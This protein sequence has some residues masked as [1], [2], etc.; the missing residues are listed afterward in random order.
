MPCCGQQKTDIGFSTQTVTARQSSNNVSNPGYRYSIYFEY[1]GNTGLTVYG[2]ATNKKYRFERPGSRVQIDPR[3]RP[4]LA[5]VAN[6][7]EV[8][9]VDLK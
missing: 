3:H 8:T 5:K 6:L 7:R 1:V 9:K 4:S 2:S